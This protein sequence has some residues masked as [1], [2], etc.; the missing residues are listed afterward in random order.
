[1]PPSAR[2]SRSAARLHRSILLAGLAW[3]LLAAVPI[4]ALPVLAADATT[5]PH[6][7][8]L[9][10]TGTVDNVMATYIE[11]GVARRRGRWRQGR[12]P[13][14][15]H[16]G[17]QPR[18]RR[19]TSCR[20][21]SRRTSRRSSGSHPAVVAPRAPERSS[22]WPANLAYMAPGTNI[23]AASPVGS[24]GEDLTGT[25]GDEGQERRDRQHPVDRRD[26]R[27]ERRLGGL[28][29]RQGG[30]VAGERGRLGRR[31]QRHRYARSRRSAT[32]PTGRPSRCDGQ[33]GDPGA[34]RTSRSS[35]SG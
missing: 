31:G 32:R 16:A 26:A 3:L 23:G 34:R 5:D 35:T 21:S 18:L 24:G 6:I 14:A 27:S 4:P 17:R 1:M 7:D 30:V 15:E 9:T 20:R 33:N 11:Q 22:R 29:R 13:D 12:D 2:A 25:I 28:D 10:A 19:N 8:V